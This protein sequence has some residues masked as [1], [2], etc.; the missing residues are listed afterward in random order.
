M[1]DVSKLEIRRG[2]RRLA[3]AVAVLIVPAA[4]LVAASKKAPLKVDSVP[5]GALVSIHLPGQ[6]GAAEL[7]VVAGTTPLEKTFD[8][9]KAGRLAIEVE[10]RGYVPGHADV[11]PDT[12]AITVTLE[13][14]AAG[15][16]DE[17]G[18]AAPGPHKL[19]VVQPDVPVIVRHFSR[20]E[21]SAEEGERLRLR[22][23]EAITSLYSGRQ[24]VEVLAPAQQGEQASAEKSLRR[25]ARTS[26]ELL[27]P[28]RLPFLSEA[29]RLENRGGRDAARALGER[30]GAAEILV[31]LGKQVVESGGMKAGKV[32]L[33]AAGTATSYASAYGAAMARGDSVFVYTVY[34]PAF[35]QGL[36][37]QAALVRCSNGEV[38]WINRGVWPPVRGDGSD[39]A[40]NAIKEL[41]S[42]LP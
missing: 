37:L 4:T 27:D 13:R 36:L 6:T 19:L 3:L 22:L 34:V 9:G 18:A 1:G 28:I 40:D 41:L 35:S 11:T 31:I 12:K 38:E 32:A 20:E 8:F 23:A 7:R 33:F 5:P 2:S 25:D 17:A 42:G 24:D 29:P 30:F 14:I 16:A 39:K 10:K 26:V 15:G 21:T